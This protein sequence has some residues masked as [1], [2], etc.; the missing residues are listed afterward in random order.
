MPLPDRPN[1]RWSMDFVS[2]QLASGRR[3]ARFLDEVA[4]HRS[5]PA[6]IVCDNGPELT[7][8]AMF[9]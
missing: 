7:R 3:L 5:L 2:D 9:F 1:Q 4:N 8:K 6:S